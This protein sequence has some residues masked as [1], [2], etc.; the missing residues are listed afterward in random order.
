[1]NGLTPRVHR[2]V[3]GMVAV[4]ALVG[5]GIQDDSAPRNIAKT[6]QPDLLASPRAADSSA[7]GADRIYLLTPGD[8]TSDEQHLRAAPRDVGNSA[9]E[10]LQSL[11]GPLTVP[12]LGAHLRT[13]I[14][15]GLVLHSAVLQTNGTLVVDVS[16]KLLT[17]AS[18]PLIVALAQ[19]VFTSVE[20]QN[21]QRIAVLVDGKPEQ[22]PVAD[23]Q[24]QTDPLTIYDYAGFIE[25]TQPAFPAI[26]S[27]KA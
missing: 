13:A 18:G 22:W 23:G 25:S 7:T 24:L 26:P 21:V 12:E 11:F 1:M 3:A 8:T 16:D 10:R 2:L 4:A 14:P 15:D 19:I 6:D 27:P 9:T 17:L 20:V 5:C